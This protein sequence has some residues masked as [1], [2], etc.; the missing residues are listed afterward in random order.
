MIAPRLGTWVDTR[1]PLPTTG[2]SEPV[3]AV[4]MTLV[5]QLRLT[6]MSL[7]GLNS[8]LPEAGGGLVGGG[9]VGGGSTGGVVPPPQ[10]PCENHGRP[11]PVMPLF[12]GHCP[13]STSSPCN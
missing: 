10:L 8:R 12:A 13:A 6:V 2:I 1:L 4:D 5:F 9:L 3:T 11:V 7:Y